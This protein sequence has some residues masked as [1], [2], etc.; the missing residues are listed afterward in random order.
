MSSPAPAEA[1]DEI[2]SIITAGRL[3]RFMSNPKWTDEQWLAAV[4][5]IEGVE[6]QL[7]EKLA[8]YIKPVPYV[9]TVT[10]LGS[11]QVNTSHPVATVTKLDGTVVAEG[12][13]LPDGWTIREHR[14]FATRPPG[15]PLLGQPF[16]L[17]TWDLGGGYSYG[18]GFGEVPRVDGVGSCSVEYLAGWGNVPALRLAI[19]K[20]ARIVF[21]NQHDDSIVV[22]DLNAD[23]P[24]EREK[25][26]WTAEELED[27][28]RFRNIAAWR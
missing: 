24:P 11:G 14:L 4:D 2:E 23:A 18:G 27:L 16:T 3:N 28:E 9:E 20:K 22:H 6:S 10:V 19:L 21:R 8:T 26:E 25:E 13:P 7:A 5:V 1:D 12:D 15:G 17:T